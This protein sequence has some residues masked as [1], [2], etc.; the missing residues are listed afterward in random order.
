MLFKAS[1]LLIAASLQGGTTDNAASLEGVIIAHQGKLTKA[2]QEL[3]NLPPSR[4]EYLERVKRAGCE[5]IFEGRLAYVHPRDLYALSKVDANGRGLEALAAYTG[6]S[7][8]SLSQL[9]PAA[10]AFLQDFL[11]TSPAA[12][13]YAELS[14]DAPFRIEASTRLWLSSGGKVIDA[15]TVDAPDEAKLPQGFYQARHT[16]PAPPRVN[17]P[18]QSQP[19]ESESPFVNFTMS[20]APTALA[21]RMQL[22]AKFSKMLEERVRNAQIEY[23]KR[24]AEVVKSMFGYEPPR[25]GLNTADMEERDRNALRSR[26]VSGYSKFGFGSPDEAEAFF[27][28]AIVEA[29]SP[30]LFLTFG[31]L[32]TQGNRS[33]HGIPLS[34]GL[35]Y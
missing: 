4:G 30:R 3:L 11:R 19:E 28:N 35:R 24:A 9:P 27:N 12:A 15:G 6:S 18:A 31:L 33:S 26:L 21:T 32:D 13:P 23:E 14:A 1:L 29:A 34:S 8:T 10:R 7:I 17:S 22:V 5:V 2:Q 16:P 20:G 25:K